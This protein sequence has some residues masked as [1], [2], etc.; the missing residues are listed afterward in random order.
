MSLRCA[1]SPSAY[2]PNVHADVLARCAPLG[3][4]RHIWLA[5]AQA[6]VAESGVSVAYTVLACDAG[7]VLAQQRVPVEPGVT[8]PELLERLF[9]LG[10]ALLLQRLPDVFGGRGQQ[11]AAPQVRSQRTRAHLDESSVVHAPKLTRE[12]S[13]LDFASGSAPELHNRVRA[14]AGWP[15]TSGRFLLVDEASGAQEPIEVKIVR[16]RAPGPR[17]SPGASSPAPSGSA[18]PAP[19]SGEAAPGEAAAAA[20]ADGAAAAAG[21]REVLFSGDAMLVPCAGGTALEVL[22]VQP[23]TKKAMAA[24]DFKNGLRGKRLLLPVQEAASA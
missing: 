12:E 14:F 6:G 9:A 16:T 5:P 22:Q 8:A 1:P 20:V 23:P 19:S 17:G 3:P 7:P 13:M 18:A 15:G 24:R 10:T 4:H 21:A 2:L 11:L